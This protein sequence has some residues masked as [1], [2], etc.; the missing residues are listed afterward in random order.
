MHIL[1]ELD[2]DYYLNRLIMRRLVASGKDNIAVKIVSF[3]KLTLSR[4]L[5]FQKALAAFHT[6]K[7][8]PMEKQVLS[9]LRHQMLSTAELIQCTEKRKTD[10]KNSNDL[11]DCLY[12]EGNCDC[13]SIITDCRTSETSFPCLPTLPTSTSSSRLHS[14]FYK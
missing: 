2:F 7:L 3:L 8:E 11:M 13:E 12:R 5:P 14:R 6:E 4:R 1:G 10:I 9:L